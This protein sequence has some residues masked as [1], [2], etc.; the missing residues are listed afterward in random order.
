ML[1]FNCHT[2]H[3]CMVYFQIWE[4]I[5]YINWLGNHGFCVHKK[6]TFHRLSVPRLYKA[7]I[8]QYNT[9]TPKCHRCT[10]GTERCYCCYSTSGWPFL[11]MLVLWFG[12]IQNGKPICNKQI[13]LWEYESSSVCVSWLCEAWFCMTELVCVCVVPIDICVVCGGGLGDCFSVCVLYCMRMCVS[14]RL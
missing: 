14:Y 1:V 6:N 8:V 3:Q 4:F 5:F 2:I 11:P 12:F 10:G 13:Y 9:V 7:Y